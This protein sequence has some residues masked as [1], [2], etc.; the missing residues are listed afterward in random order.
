MAEARDCSAEDILPEPRK[1]SE[2]SLDQRLFQDCYANTDRIVKLNESLVNKPGIQESR[3]SA[4]DPKVDLFQKAHAAIGTTGNLYEE[5]IRRGTG[6]FVRE[7]GLFATVGHLVEPL[8]KDLFVWTADKQKHK[9]EIVARDMANDL[10]LLKVKKTSPD[11]KFPALQL[12]SSSNLKKGDAITGLG[13]ALPA[14]PLAPGE[15]ILNPGKF[16]NIY[17]DKNVGLSEHLD[18]VNPEREMLRTAMRTESGNSGGPVVDKNHNVIAL[19]DYGEMSTPDGTYAETA[20][21][22]V[23]RLTELIISYGK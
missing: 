16:L 6:F 5:S 18:Y 3:L 14:Q 8:G 22:P 1:I 23:E 15:T 13:S 2:L 21:V 11:E 9:A 20:L 19:T 7:D 12:G 17:K 10:V 4:S